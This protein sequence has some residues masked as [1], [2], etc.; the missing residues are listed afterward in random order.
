MAKTIGL[1]F[2]T[3]PT[4]DL[5]TAVPADDGGICLD[6]MTV[7][8]LKR[9]AEDNGFDIGSASKKSDIIQAIMGR[10]GTDTEEE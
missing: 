1:T 8:Q 9:F 7:P 3:D 5:E 6:D 10:A 2:P 4:E